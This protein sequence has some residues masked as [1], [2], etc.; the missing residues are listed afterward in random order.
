MPGACE[1]VFRD[2]VLAVRLDVVGPLRPGA[3]ALTDFQING[4]SRP[5]APHW[6]QAPAYRAQIRGDT[7]FCE[8]ACGFGFEEGA[9]DFTAGAVGFDQRPVRVDARYQD[10]DGGCPSSSEGSTQITVTLV[11]ASAPR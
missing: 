6:T 10:G 3:F 7:L 11:P 9:Y 2:P 5:P 4:R 8:G 1:H